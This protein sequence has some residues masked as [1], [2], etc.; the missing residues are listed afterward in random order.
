MLLFATLDTFSK[1][2]YNTVAKSYRGYGERE[3][4]EIPDSVTSIGERV[5]YNYTS[6]TIYCEAE[7]IPS[8]WH[9]DWNKL[10]WSNSKVSTVWNYKK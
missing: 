1:I 7:S 6:L 4:L 9:F 3:R 5:F 8:G 2:W 10:N